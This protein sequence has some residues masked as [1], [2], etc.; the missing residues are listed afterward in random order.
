[1]SK[2]KQQQQKQSKIK[3]IIYINKNNDNMKQINRKI[4][5]IEIHMV[6]AIH[7]SKSHRN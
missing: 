3:L 5:Q 2:Q 6:K 7:L 1:M 4:E